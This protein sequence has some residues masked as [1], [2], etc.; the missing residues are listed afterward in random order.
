MDLSPEDFAWTTREI[1]KIADICCHGRVVSVLEGGYGAYDHSST[2]TKS[3]VYA[4]RGRSNSSG[5]S[6]AAAAAASTTTAPG[7]IDAHAVVSYM[8]RNIL[9]DAVVSH[10]HCL[11]DPYGATTPIVHTNQT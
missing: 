5:G 8:N 6:A 9:A 3:G 1:M 10:V 4:T 7:E 2:S 11:M